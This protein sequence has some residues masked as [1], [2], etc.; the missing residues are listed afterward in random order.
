MIDL[1]AVEAS[2]KEALQGGDIL[3]LVD[4]SQSQV[5]DLGSEAF[6]EVVLKDAS[7]EDQVRAILN[8][9]ANKAESDQSR[10]EWHVRSVWKVIGIGAVQQAY[11]TNGWPVAATSISVTL[12]SGSREAVVQVL[13]TT[14]ATST[15]RRVMGQEPP[16][17]DLVLAYVESLLRR[18]GKQA[19]NPILRGTLEISEASALSIYQL[20]AKSA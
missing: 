13:V 12:T 19:W 16:L 18:S 10:V 11:G 6:V 9:W 17:Q 3:S 8:D 7:K 5:V 2:L 14:L 15:L 4:L 1:V 20:L